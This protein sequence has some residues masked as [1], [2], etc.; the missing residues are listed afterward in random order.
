[1]Q[2]HSIQVHIISTWHDEGNTFSNKSH[3][4]HV[5]GPGQ[6]F[7]TFVQINT[8]YLH[9]LCFLGSAPCPA[10]GVLLTYGRVSYCLA[11]LSGS[12]R[13]AIQHFHDSS[14][15]HTR[16]LVTH[17]RSTD[18][19]ASQSLPTVGLWISDVSVIACCWSTDRPT[20]PSSPSVGLRTSRRLRRHRL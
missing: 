2:L 18:H 17:F 3:C 1:L 9:L 12:R 20:A 13:E 19:P 10:S 4:K 14:S 16:G 7:I 5:L 8:P 11:D 15:F 6:L